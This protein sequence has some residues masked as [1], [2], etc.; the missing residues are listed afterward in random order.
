MGEVRF[1]LQTTSRDASHP[2]VRLLQR[3]AHDFEP[4]KCSNFGSRD[5]VVINSSSVGHGQLTA[6]AGRSPFCAVG[7]CKFT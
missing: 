2:R 4:Y 6:A 3:R 1:F 7:T 5:M